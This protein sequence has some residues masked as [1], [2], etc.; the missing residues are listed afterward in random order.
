MHSIMT[1]E[2]I[3]S[4]PGEPDAPNSHRDIT[5]LLRSIDGISL[6]NV[7][8]QYLDRTT[9]SY[10]SGDPS[11]RYERVDPLLTTAHLRRIR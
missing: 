10:E 7:V 11:P 2:R 9:V 6:V 5:A 3:A 8:N 4:R 1:V